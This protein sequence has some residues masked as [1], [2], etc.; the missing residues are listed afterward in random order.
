MPE[1]ESTEVAAQSPVG[2][3]G[4]RRFLKLIAIGGGTALA[5]YYL[6]QFPG[7]VPAPPEGL[8]GVPQRTRRWTMLIDL[9]RCDGCGLC[10]DACRL[11]HNVA[12]GQEWMKVY[13][14]TDNDGEFF[15]PRPCMH[16]ENAPCIKVC[17][18]NATF[19]NEDGLVVIDEQRCIGCR[20]CMAAC[21]Y[22]ARYFN[23]SEPVEGDEILSP[24]RE[25]GHEDHQRGVVEKCMFCAHR[26]DEGRLPACVVG[27][28]MGAIYFGD[29]NEDFL[30]NGPEKI[31]LSAVLASQ[32][33]FRWKEELGTE[34]RVYYLPARR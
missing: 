9:R 12:D 13:T 15:L 26:T 24:T 8:E 23:W 10:T 32:E 20:Y 1:S 22:D 7:V 5:G 29:A 30:S 27:C 18:V 33:A 4:R 19:Y 31:R 21:P 17:P 34:P 3:E 6:A 2:A 16:C 11:E 28:P 25:R 14:R